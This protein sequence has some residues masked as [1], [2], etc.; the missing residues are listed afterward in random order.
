MVFNTAISKSYLFILAL[1]AKP[2]STIPRVNISD[3]DTHLQNLEPS[4][5]PGLETISRG[6]YNNPE[7]GGNK[8]YT[9][10]ITV[11]YFQ[12]NKSGEWDVYPNILTSLPT[13]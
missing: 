4:I 9:H 11:S 3:L 8:T 5:Y 10:N 2:C 1:L 7:I 6:I 13:A 12:N